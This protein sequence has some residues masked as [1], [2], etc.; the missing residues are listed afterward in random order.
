MEF[1]VLD[2]LF[3][4]HLL[5]KLK[6]CDCLAGSLHLLFFCSKSQIAVDGR[7]RE[8]EPLSRHVSL[9][10]SSHLQSKHRTLTL[11]FQPSMKVCKT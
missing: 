8:M 5:L 4:L 11:L 6:F 2:K 3:D 7:D 9:L 1:S 10:L